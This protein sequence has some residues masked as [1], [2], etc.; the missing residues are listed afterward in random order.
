[1]PGLATCVTGLS[2]DVG[3]PST[4]QSWSFHAVW[5]LPHPTVDSY[6]RLMAV[7]SDKKIEYDVFISHAREDK[8]DFVRPLAAALEA[9]HLRPWYDEFTLRP[10]DS[11]RRS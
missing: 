2:R 3:T 11:L 9:R 8:E 4:R 1:M 5:L 10:G 7:D 6:P